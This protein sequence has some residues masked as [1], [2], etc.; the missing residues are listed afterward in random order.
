MMGRRALPDGQR[1]IAEVEKGRPAMW[2]RRLFFAAAAALAALSPAVPTGPMPDA[3]APTAAAWRPAQGEGDR[4]KF[5]VVD[6]VIAFTEGVGASRIE[7]PPPAEPRFGRR[8]LYVAQLLAIANARQ[9]IWLSQG[10][11]VPD[12]RMLA[13]LERAAQRGVDVR[14]VLP[15]QAEH[16]LPFH[17]GRARYGR[18]LGAGVHVFERRDALLPT[19]TA[20]AAGIWTAFPPGGE[21]RGNDR[22]ELMLFDRGAARQLELLFRLDEAASREVSLADWRRRS[23]ACRFKEWLARCC[24]RLL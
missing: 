23:F 13:A 12:E 8:E 7:A 17:A 22:S 3:T 18:L 10:Y 16:W 14:L 2:L 19:R 9:R 6:G 4:R 1:A 11:F 20:G 24:E 5:L 15:G 21:G